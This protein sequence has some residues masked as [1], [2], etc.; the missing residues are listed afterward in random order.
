MLE[1]IS[2]F[3]LSTQK[4]RKNT[5]CAQKLGNYIEFQGKLIKKWNGKMEINIQMG[6]HQF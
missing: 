3:G 2:L 1:K 6:Y 4:L 5:G